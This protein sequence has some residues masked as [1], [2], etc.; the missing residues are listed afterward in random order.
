MNRLT[1]GTLLACATTLWAQDIPLFTKDFPPEEFAARRARIYDAI[2]S[3]AI[4]LVQG[5]P[6]PEGYTR[7]RQNNEFY[8]LCGIEAPHAYLL[9]DGAARKATVFL[10]RRNER[11]ERSEGKVLS[12]EDADQVKQL[13]GIDEV[14]AVDLLAEALVRYAR[15]DWMPALY[16]P[17]QPPEN[18]ANS[19]D[20][21]LR[22]AADISADPW[23]GR[24]ARHERFLELVRQRFPQFPI[25]DLSPVL[26]KM[27]L[28]KSPR[29]IAM[30]R[31]ATKL[32]G[33][34][35]LEGMKSTKAGL[36][37]HELDGMA[38]FIFFR[39]GA[40]GDAYY[41]LIASGPNAM[42]PHYNAGKRTMDGG[43]LLLMDYA[44]DYGY[45]M[46][47]VTRMWPVNG[48]FNDW[49]TQLYTF[50]L[51]CYEAILA[52]IRPG[53]P[54]KQIQKEAHA[55]MEALLARTRFLKPEYE[56]A[57]KKFVEPFATPSGRLGHWIGMATHDVGGTVEMLAPGMVFTIEPAL[58]VPEEKIYI[59]LED[60]VLVTEKGSEV[61]SD[62]VPRTL[63]G[64]E[65]VMKEDG[66]LDKYSKQ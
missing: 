23:D 4:A 43:E 19:R 54:V 22:V 1:A 65:K 9:L 20:L 27:R 17:L 55:K 47:D 33:L 36:M 42:F 8:Y 18:Y 62:F 6:S 37:E 34:A 38:K 61:L 12:F 2:G 59:R 25:Q 30:I 16:S 52:G 39:N 41:S 3:K 57:A 63:A 60:M 21:A 44:P 31:E 50:Y 53:V 13:T 58:V 49:Q 10:P 26:D 29:E 51:E 14:S 15:Q 11:R 45:Y 7:F 32:S 24:P 40:Q 28:I 66:L 5:A 48:R 35:L 56:R 64:I 46:A